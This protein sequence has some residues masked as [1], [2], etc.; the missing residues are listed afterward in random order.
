[1]TENMKKLLEIVSA[2]KELAAK[3]NGMGKEDIITLAKELGVE[4]TEAD[5]SQNC[6]LSDD[7]LD[8]VAGGGKCICSFGG[9][10][11]ASEGEKT[12][13]CVM[14]GGGEYSDGSVRCVCIIGGDGNW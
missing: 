12:C 8:T 14:G 9:G 4:L 13:A 2:S 6:E 5:F 10:G 3:I 7:E 11:K 1:M